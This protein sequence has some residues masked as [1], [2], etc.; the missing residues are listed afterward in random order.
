MEPFLLLFARSHQM[1][2][3]IIQVYNFVWHTI[4]F[5]LNSNL[6]GI[7]TLFLLLFFDLLLLL[8]LFN[9]LPYFNCH[10]SEMRVPYIDKLHS[11]Y[12]KFTRSFLQCEILIDALKG[13]IFCSLCNAFA[14][15]NIFIFFSRMSR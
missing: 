7:L 14:I 8:L 4:A 1:C 13:D 15:A 11:I 6:Y 12:P 9:V 10:V 5:T 2:I 3:Y